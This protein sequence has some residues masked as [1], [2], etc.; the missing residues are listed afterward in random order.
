[1]DDEEN[2]LQNWWQQED[3][4]QEWIDSQTEDDS[5]ETG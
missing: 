3:S 4:D 5:N 2:E 1:M